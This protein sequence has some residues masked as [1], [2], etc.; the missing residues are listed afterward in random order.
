MNCVSS[1]P[2]GYYFPPSSS[3]RICSVCDPSC[4]TCDGSYLLCSSCRDGFYLNQTKCSKCTLSNCKACKLDSNSSAEICEQCNSPFILQGTKC[5]SQC[6]KGYFEN[7][8]NGVA[9]QCL[10]CREKT[11]NCVDC[12][13]ATGNCLECEN[14]LV[15]DGGICNT[16]CSKGRFDSD[17][18]CSECSASISKCLECKI[19]ESKLRCSKCEE[20]NDVT[21]GLILS[22][23]ST[24]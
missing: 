12:E 18:K 20:S 13:A 23:D 24:K 3:V 7:K 21:T 22:S 4:K 5:V 15:L 17:R 9:L 1:C 6:E 16:T 10:P 2:E 19:V 14:P 11:P 8:V